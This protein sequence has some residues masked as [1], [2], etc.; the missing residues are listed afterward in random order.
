MANMKC[1]YNMKVLFVEMDA[2]V[3]SVGVW[4]H[5]AQKPL[6]QPSDESG[7]FVKHEAVAQ[8]RPQAP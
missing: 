1:W 6:P 3:I 2:R 7:S 8:E 5:A 4:S